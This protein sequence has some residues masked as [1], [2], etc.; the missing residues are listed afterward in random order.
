MVDYICCMQVP[1]W[2]SLVIGGTL[3]M[4]LITLSAGS[5]VDHIWIIL[6]Q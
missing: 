3:L 5:R 1:T 2:S 6:A 4:G